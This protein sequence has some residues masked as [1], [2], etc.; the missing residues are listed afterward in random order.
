MFELLAPIF[1]VAGGVLAGVPL[2]LHMLRRTPAVRMPFSTVRFLSPTL[3]KT[4]KRSTIEHWPLMLL[5]MLAVALIAFAF[6]R[7][8]QR[9][10][11]DKSDEARGANRIAVVIDAS[12]SMRRDGL[13]EAV[14]REL[15][16]VFGELGKN[17][18]LSVAAYSASIRKL[19]TAEEWQSTNPANRAAL[20]DR[21]IENYEPDWL[22][23]NTANALLESAEEVSRETA[24]TESRHARQV[25]LITDFQQGSSLDELR[26]GK[27]PESVKL[28]LRIVKPLQ[29]G[30]AGL[31]LVEDN[32]TGRIRVRVT[33]SGD[34]AVTKYLLRT[35]DANGQPVGTPLTADVGGGQRRTFVMPESVDGQA[36]IVGVELLGDSHPFDNVV[37]LP[38]DDRGVVQIAHAGPV[39]ANNADTMRYYLQ[40]A[41]DGNELEPIDVADLVNDSGIAVP[42]AADIRLVFVTD[43]VPDPLVASLDGVLQR[44]GMVVI[45]MKSADMATALKS[46]LPP[47]CSVT[48]A[49][50]KDYAMFGQIDFASP[51]FANFSD[52][53]FSDFSSIRFWHFRNLKLDEGSSDSVRILARFD[54]GSPAIVE[55]Q[56]P[57]GGRVFV[58]ATGWQPDD[59]QWALSTRFPP[60]I[61]RFVTL[62]NPRQGGHHLMEVGQRINPSAL[63][64]SQNWTLTRP[65]GSP[66]M[67]PLMNPA[68][69]EESNAENAALADSTAVSSLVLD[70]PGRWTLSSD[71]T[72]GQK[73]ISLLVT[74][75]AS[76][77]RTDPLPAG[78]L[79]AL[80]M[81]PDVAA[82]SESSQKP[83]DAKIAAQL[84]ASELES[85]QKFWRWVLL[86]G[87]GCLALEGIVSFSLERRQQLNVA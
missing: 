14:T 6:G 44:D 16:N 63:T 67:P 64:G 82:V 9:V 66:F 40:R 1:A 49:S 5:R 76:E 65:D 29:P 84:D 73:S 80:G 39:D 42:P 7:P 12:A 51:L 25:I 2:V 72:E 74:V 75:A 55:Y 86:A 37:D 31:S 53:R 47:G 13:R 17:D 48:E 22:G 15:Q 18:T 81:S 21:A 57:S 83:L 32:R 70:E 11:I 46:L 71:S 28:D 19:I 62:A 79:Q 68:A 52:A 60:M 20:I 59:S 26:S 50:V 10:A 56:H 85:R 27:W 87:L 69:I 36:R 43:V 77:S 8:F 38:I 54:T 4:T 33:N 61:Q 3:P 35:F 41:L 34:A 78:Q 24:T 23:T 45:A 30:N 58:L